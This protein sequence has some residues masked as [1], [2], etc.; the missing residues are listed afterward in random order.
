MEPSISEEY[1][2]SEY[3]YLCLITLVILK[4]SISYIKIIF[5]DESFKSDFSLVSQDA[6]NIMEKT[7]FRYLIVMSLIYGQYWI[8][9]AYLVPLYQHFHNFSLSEIALL[10]AVYHSS[11][12]IFGPIILSLGNY[13]GYK[14]LCIA[15]CLLTIAETTLRLTLLQ[16]LAFASQALSGL[17]SYLIHSSFT[18]WI[19]LES[20]LQLGDS[21]VE[22]DYLKYIQGR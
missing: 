10:F 4:A 3:Y 15:S 8:K 5:P 1:N 9:A 22:E 14:K 13:S 20:S 11:K 2:L 17:S 19:I 16:P 18:S 7:T 12:L 6:Y 21:K